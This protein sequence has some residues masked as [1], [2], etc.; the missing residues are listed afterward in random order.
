V[1]DEIAVCLALAVGA[2]V[3][4]GRE[5]SR[6]S[7]KSGVT[8]ETPGFHQISIVNGT[9]V[10]EDFRSFVNNPLP[11]PNSGVCGTGI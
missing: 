1:A 9:G 11:A 8:P 5:V 7:V 3:H 2:S 4:P 6:P 10:T